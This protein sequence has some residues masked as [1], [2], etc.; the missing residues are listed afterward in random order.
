MSYMMN[1]IY[2]KL[3]IEGFEPKPERTCLESWLTVTVKGHK[4]SIYPACWYVK[5]RKE[6][7]E[8]VKIFVDDKLHSQHVPGSFGV[9]EKGTWDPVNYAVE[10][11]KVF[12]AAPEESQRNSR[13]KKC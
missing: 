9:M 13:R 3:A 1:K 4:I 2:G 6:F 10:W 5:E 11:V 12:A 7:Y 8:D